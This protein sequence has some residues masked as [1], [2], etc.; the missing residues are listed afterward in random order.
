M[1]CRSIPEVANGSGSSTKI[2]PRIRK[3]PSHPS[4]I[5]SAFKCGVHL[6]ACTGL[7]QFRLISLNRSRT[8]CKERTEKIDGAFF[9]RL[10]Q[11]H[12][13]SMTVW[14]CLPADL[15]HDA[16]Q[17]FPDYLSPLLSSNSPG[18]SGPQRS[19]PST[20]QWFSTLP[21]CSRDVDQV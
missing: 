6:A 3:L 13:K 17:L 5:D 7:F 15:L 12:S 18:S 10:F 2:S 20:I 11:F 19:I 1:R 14:R 4:V 21:Q 16:T 9:S 8:F